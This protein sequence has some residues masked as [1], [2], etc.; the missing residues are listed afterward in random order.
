MGVLV[1]A[2]RP[3][4]FSSSCSDSDDCMRGRRRNKEQGKEEWRE[5]KPKGR[6]EVERGQDIAV[7]REERMKE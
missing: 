1:G 6:Q 4:G 7:N 2:K 5:G 3:S